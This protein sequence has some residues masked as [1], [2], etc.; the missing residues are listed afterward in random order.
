VPTASVIFC[1]GTEQPEYWEAKPLGFESERFSLNM[2][3]SLIIGIVAGIVLGRHFKISIFA[4]A[5]SVARTC[6]QFLRH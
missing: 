2:L 1:Q 4:P 5:T 6:R 3:A